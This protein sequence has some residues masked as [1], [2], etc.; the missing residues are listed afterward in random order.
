MCLK[1]C[2]LCQS[3]ADPKLEC[4]ILTPICSHSVFTRSLVLGDD[5][6]LHIYS[7]D[8]G[9]LSVSCDGDEPFTVS[10][11]GSITV[12]KADICA[13]FI[14]LK[15]DSFVDILNRK[16]MKWNSSSHDEREV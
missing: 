11:Q 8:D 3:C 12:E 16:M 1:S 9:P 6:V 7:D 4:M 5:A 14:R 15:N 2:R 13:S 10:A